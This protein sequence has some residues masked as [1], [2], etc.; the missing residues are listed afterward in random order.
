MH[1]ALLIIAVVKLH[2]F[3]VK[4]FSEEMQEHHYIRLLDN[5]SF[6]GFCG[7]Q[8]FR[9]DGPVVFVVLLYQDFLKVKVSLKL[10]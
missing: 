9:P 7:F 10:L 5:L 1:G 6:T 2:G 3:L 8:D 4:F